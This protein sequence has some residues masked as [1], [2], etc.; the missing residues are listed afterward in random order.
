MG[1]IAAA[2]QKLLAKIVA[3]GLLIVAA[4]AC[5]GGSTTSS[6]AASQSP[7]SGSAGPILDAP[8]ASIPGPK[9]TIAVG[10]IDAIGSVT[11]PFGRGT[12]STSVAAML[13][14]ALIE[15]GR[16]IVI[17][18]AALD[19]VLT[20]QELASSGVAQGSDAPKPG[21]MIP[22]QYLVV[23]SISEFSTADEGSTIGIGGSLG[24]GGSSL[25]SGQNRRRNN[26]GGAPVGALS[27]SEQ[28]GRVG[29][30]LRI[31]NT[32]TTKVE[33]GFTVRREVRST[34]VGA[35]LLYAGV[36][37]GGNKFWNTPLGDATREALN[38][39]VVNI[40]RIVSATTWQAQVAEFDGTLVYVNAGRTSGLR[41]GDRLSITR[42]G[43]P[44]TDPATGAVLTVRK[45][46]LGALEV[47][48]VEDDFSTGYFA[49]RGSE[50]P[51]R[52]DFIELA[53]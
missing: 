27:Y 37:L 32:R 50:M 48:S 6:E 16:F 31:V 44:I 51:K 46:T 17:E 3:I 8:V 39:A 12:V 9:R 33:G 7:S 21:K 15:S 29:F 36:V 41:V 35:N 10:N 43:T 19:Q 20:E 38:E 1:R 24:G 23:G 26:Q 25:G 18:R 22:A 45:S 30:D 52:G 53:N 28:S 40:V 5:T 2:Q 13:N 11:G 34:G 4:S 47:V 14:T 42:P 49:P